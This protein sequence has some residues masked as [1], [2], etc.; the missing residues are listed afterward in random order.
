MKSI[1]ESTPSVWCNWSGSVQ[2]RPRVRLHPA[3]EGDLAQNIIRAPAPVRVAGSGHSFTPLN[4]TEGSLISLE[5]MAGVV[6]H[7]EKTAQATIT[8]GI[9]LHDLGPALFER[10]L[11]LVNQ[12][13]ID[14]QTLAGA[15]GTGTHGTGKTLGSLSSA[16]TGFRLVTAEGDVLSCSEDENKDVFDAGRVSFGTL[17]VMSAITMQCHPAYGLKETVG[18]LS[19]EATCAALDEFCQTY[20]HFEFF[21]FPFSDEVI[22]KTLEKT[23]ETPRLVA[24]PASPDRDSYDNKII[25]WCCE[26]SRS[27]P[28]LRG[29]LQRFLTRAGAKYY[30]MKGVNPSRTRWSHQAFPSPRTVRFNEMEYAVPA[31]AGPECVREVGEVMKRSGHNFMFPIEYRTIAA[32]NIWLSPFYK[33]DSVSISIHQ[34]ARDPW[35]ELFAEA[36]AVFRRYEGRP[37]WGKLHTLTAKKAANL[38]PRWEDFRAVRQRLDPKGHLLNTY[39]KTLFAA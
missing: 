21:W 11:G 6:S 16:V 32:D 20:R 22:L 13:D 34:Y 26:I 37:H 23:D 12:G 36:E 35:R 30:M 18:R 15:V 31:A 8:P 7:D 29:P 33:R 5:N 4:E 9:T 1:K 38:Y 25:R 3:G 39:L 24:K 2:G 19:F 28:W 14:A 27:L 10:G 17:G